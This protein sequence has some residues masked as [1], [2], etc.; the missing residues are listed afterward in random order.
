MIYHITPKHIW[1][2][3]TGDPGFE[4]PAFTKEGF[5]HCCTPDQVEGVLNR[6]FKGVTNLLMLHI[7][8]SKL[9][10]PLRYEG[11]P[12][13]EQFPHIYGKINKSA[14]EQVT[15]ISSTP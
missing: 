2:E 5:I 15:A 12:G 14:V 4:P 7:Y 13:G 9:D 10:N 11:V 6:Y 1:Q 8:E 3:Q